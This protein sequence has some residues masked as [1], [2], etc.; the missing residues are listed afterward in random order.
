MGQARDKGIRRTHPHANRGQYMS[1]RFK[2]EVLQKLSRQLH[3][4]VFPLL[5]IQSKPV[6]SYLDERVRQALITTRR[7]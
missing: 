3:S 5:K 6:V 4:V 1:A 7:M 2:T